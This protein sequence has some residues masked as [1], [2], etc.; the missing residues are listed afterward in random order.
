MSALLAPR[1]IATTTSRSRS[2]STVQPSRAP[3]PGCPARA[4]A[5]VH[6]PTRHPRRQHRLPGRRRQHRLDDPLRLGVLEQVAARA[7]VQRGLDLVG[8]VE[9][10]EHDDGGRVP[11]RADRPGRRDAVGARHAQVHEHDVDRVRVEQ[12]RAP[13]TPSAHLRDDAD[14]VRAVE[15]ERQPGPHEGVVVDDDHPDAHGSHGSHASS[16]EPVRDRLRRAASRPAARS[17]RSARSARSRSRCRGRDRRCRSP[18]ATR[19][20][21]STSTRTS[22][23]APGACRRALVS[24]SWQVR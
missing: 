3:R 16:T 8:G 12:R 21:S 14:P 22:T 2:V 7:G 1:P 4:R 5:G 24:P 17:V 9:R 10:G 15:Q 11:A 23:A 6:E 13:R 20:P 18:R 19:S